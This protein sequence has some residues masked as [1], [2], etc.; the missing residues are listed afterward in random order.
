LENILERHR[1]IWNDK[2]ILRIIYEE[3]YKKIIDNLSKAEG[4]ILELGA[5]SGN[6]KDYMPGVISA[7]I[8]NCDWLDMCFDA[9]QMPF[10][11]DTIANIVLVDVLHHL[12]NPVKFLKETGRVLKS[13]GRLLMLEPFPSA[14]SLFIYKK[15][16]P[17]PFIFD[18]DYF[19][20]NELKTKDPWDSN[21][22]IPFLIFFKNADK[23]NE[24]FGDVF[25][26][27]KKEKLSFILYPASGGFE[28]KS[29]IPDSLIPV[30]RGLETVLSPFKDFL[31]FRCF[32]VIE[33]K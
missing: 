7:D 25:K 30:F 19:S 8:E 26:I 4:K 22:A 2:K 16:H 33:K 13:G 12:Y 32:I 14:F 18:V 10:E 31:A 1:E 11:N 6:F 24:S 9:H 23:F 3:W 5:G 29:F 27:I 15:F 20:M 28:N 21:Q 17:E